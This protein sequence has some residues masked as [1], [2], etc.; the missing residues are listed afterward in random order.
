MPVSSE[1]TAVGTTITAV[2]TSGQPVQYVY[3]QDGDEG[4][5]VAYVGGSDV[6]ASNGI[7]LSKDNVTV[8]ELYDF[9]TLF[10]ITTG[11]TG[12]VRSLTVS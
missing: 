1:S 11:S 2:A 6:S 7:K 3:L 10:A 4:D 8:F 12:S 5:T 9:D